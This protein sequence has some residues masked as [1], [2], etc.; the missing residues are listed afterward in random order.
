MIEMIQNP[1]PGTRTAES[2]IRWIA[3]CTVDGVEYEATSRNGA[4]C[5]LARVLVAAG[6]PDQPVIVREPALRTGLRRASL[7]EM[8]RW[9]YSDREVPLTRNR[10]HP[11]L[12]R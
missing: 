10:W 11:Y 12:P 3:R 7:H 4:S 5:A 9:T 8:A 1:V 6:I 2:E